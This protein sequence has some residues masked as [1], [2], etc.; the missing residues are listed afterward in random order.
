MNSYLLPVADLRPLGLSFDIYNTP[1]YPYMRSGSKN[2][3]SSFVYRCKSLS[4]EEINLGRC[5]H[6]YLVASSQRINSFFDSS[7]C[8]DTNNRYPSNNSLPLVQLPLL[9]IAH[10]ITGDSYTCNLYEPEICLHFSVLNERTLSTN[11][12]LKSASFT[13]NIS[14]SLLLNLPPVRDITHPGR[15]ICLNHMFKKKQG[16]FVIM[17]CSVTSSQQSSP[18]KNLI[19]IIAYKEGIPV[20][21]YNLSLTTMDCAYAL[22]FKKFEHDHD[23]II[24]K[25][26]SRCISY[27]VDIN[28]YGLACEH[29]LAPHYYKPFN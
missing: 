24:I 8:I 26:S 2:I 6:T 28:K 18:T 4:C 15:Y 11:E 1:R 13:S 29:S 10:Y 7:A 5:Q 22:D 23:L 27:F 9:H 14:A 3:Y 16:Y 17:P 19:E 12:S 21:N 25:Y 20:A